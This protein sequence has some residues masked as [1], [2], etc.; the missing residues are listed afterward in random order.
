MQC[1]SKYVLD[2][3]YFGSSLVVSKIKDVGKLR[4]WKS[5]VKICDRKLNLRAKMRVAGMQG[6]ALPKM[7]GVNAK[8]IFTSLHLRSFATW[9]PN[10]ELAASIAIRQLAAMTTS[11]LSTSK[12]HNLAFNVWQ[13]HYSGR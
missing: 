5:Y 9:S 10:T 12:R 3:V 8:L 1:G 11:P 7:E 13:S 2:N 6:P 4:R